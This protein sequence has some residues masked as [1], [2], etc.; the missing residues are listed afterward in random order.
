MVQSS[1][2]SVKAQKVKIRNERLLIMDDE[3]SILAIL[4]RVLTT[5][6]YSVDTAAEGVSAS[7]LYQKAREE[8]HPYKVVLL[9]LTIPGRMGGIETLARLKQ[10]DPTVKAIVMSGYSDSGAL[11]KY[12]EYGFVS[13]ISK[14]F[15][16]TELYQTIENILISH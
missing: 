15:K 7:M 3:K 13:L 4:K 12:E 14:P 5:A 8:E 9:D 1:V 10:I 11:S 16:V 2:S 6:G